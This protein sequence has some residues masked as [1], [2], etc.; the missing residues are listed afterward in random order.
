MRK[1]QANESIEKEM[2]GFAHL[3]ISVGSKEQVDQLKQRLRADG[4][5][6]IGEPR[7][8]GYGYYESIILDPDG[9]RV[10]VIS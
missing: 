3:A 10:E 1:P 5:T 9:S 6:V 2:L 4:F 8:T 7:T